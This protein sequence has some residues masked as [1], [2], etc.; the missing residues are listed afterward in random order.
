DFFDVSRL[1][2][3]T[4]KGV[5]SVPWKGNAAPRIAETASGMLNSIGLQNPGVEAFCARDLKW[6]AQQDVPVIVNVCGHASHEYREVIERLE[7]EDAVSA[8]E[9]NISCPNVDA[10]GMAFGTD[11]ASAATIV[12]LCRAATSR[13]L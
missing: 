13:P 5:S 11:C 4:T 8:Y 6:L 7:D 2:A 3:V 10:G 12:A 9:L 1:G